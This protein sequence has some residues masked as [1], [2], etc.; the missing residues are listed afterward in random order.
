MKILHVDTGR[1]WRGGQAQV[2]NLVRSLDP[3]RTDNHL[4]VPEESEL[5]RRLVDEDVGD[6]VHTHPLRG[7]WDVSAGWTI[8]DLHATHEYDL[9]HAHDSHGHGIVWWAS[10]IFSLPPIV[11]TRRLE[12]SVG[13][14]IFSRK[15]YRDADR[16]IAISE[17]V[18][19]SLSD[20]G[21][22]EERIHV[23]PSGVALEHVTACSP[24][25]A[26]IEEL[27]LDPD[28]PVVGNVGALTHQKDQETFIRMAHHLIEETGRD[29]TQ[30]VIA[31][32]GELEDELRSLI[33]ELGIGE[34][35]KLAGFRE[36]I[37]PF[38][39][40]FDLFVLT[41]VF[42]GLCSTLLQVM[43]ARVPIVA[44]NVGGVS[45]LIEDGVTGRLV[46]PEKPVEIAETVDDLLS[47]PDEQ[48]QYV[49]NAFDRV[50]SYDYDQLAR[51]T[52]EE[53]YRS[54][55]GEKA[56]RTS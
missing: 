17:P 34:Q 48:K 13:Q 11:V 21:V 49:Q 46:S 27:G 25:G 47:R 12:L 1:T 35:C 37:V 10:R 26:A 54:V 52:E 2:F 4:L 23:I 55:A 30:F 32:S 18:K 28:R 9:V 31:G 6:R 15:K 51:R 43:G 19:E 38:I 40:T 42:E 41:S 14:N 24:D 45:T 20:G 50:L 29:R 53:V 22:D 5:H 7:E 3:D 39:K 44:T 36:R 56:S 33:Q 8:S 16:F